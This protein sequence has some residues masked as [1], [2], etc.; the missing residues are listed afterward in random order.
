M[1]E[2]ET[3]YCD[4]GVDAY[5]GFEKFV[6]RDYIADDTKVTGYYGITDD[7]KGWYYLKLT[8]KE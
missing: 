3:H 2:H 8:T 5:Y 1:E 6:F 4:P 7:T